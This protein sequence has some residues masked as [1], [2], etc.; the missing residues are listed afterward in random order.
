MKA[1]TCILLCVFFSGCATE[2]YNIPQKTIP[3][4]TSYQGTCINCGRVFTITQENIDEEDK[5]I[6]KSCPYCGATIDSLRR[7]NKRYLYDNQQEVN[8]TIENYVLLKAATE[9]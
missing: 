8:K 3:Q 9:H 4:Q 7:A 6:Q 1:L 2:S 5:G